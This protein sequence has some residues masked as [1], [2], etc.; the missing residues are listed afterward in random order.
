MDLRQACG[1]TNPSVSLATWGKTLAQGVERREKNV[2]TSSD[3]DDALKFTQ[4]PDNKLGPAGWA[5]KDEAR[6]QLQ[7]GK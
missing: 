4:I 7:Y 2:L 6:A 5:L 3:L 1:T